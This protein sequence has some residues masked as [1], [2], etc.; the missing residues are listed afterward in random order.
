LYLLPPPVKDEWSL[1]QPIQ[2]LGLKD[3]AP[4]ASTEL[5]H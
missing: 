2:D 5:A 1:S 4:V 3:N